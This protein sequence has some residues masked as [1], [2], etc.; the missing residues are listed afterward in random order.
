MLN[1]LKP[2]SKFSRNVLTLMTG[3]TI[4][5]AIPI[6]ISPILTRI[7]TPEDFGIFALYIAI[8][9]FISII[10]TARYE[11][12]I[13][14]PKKDEDAVN[15]LFLSLCIMMFIVI[16]TTILIL[17]F[18][19]TIIEL[20]NAKEIG[21][22]IYLIPISIFIAGLNQS[23]NYWS[24]R[25]EYFKNMSSAQISQ[26]I[27]IGIFQPLLG[28]FNIFG[29]LIIGNILGRVINTF[30]LIN[31]FISND[32]EKIK[33]VNKNIMIEQ[34]K[35]YKDFPL[36]N[37]LHA[38]TDIL[39][40]SGSVMLISSFFG[41]TIL[42]LYS[43][44]LRVLQV[45][46][47]I[48]GSALGKVLYSKLTLLYNDK[49]PLYPYVKKISINLFLISLPIFLFLYIIIPDLFGF[50]FGEKWRIA[51][52]YSK[53]LLPYLFVN[54][55]ISPI[56]IVPI[57]VKKQKEYFYLNLIANIGMPL[58]ILIG[59]KLSLSFIEILEYL[60]LFLSIFYILMLLWILKESKKVI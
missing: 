4:A 30:I 49:K 15:I 6:A 33:F 19:T 20:L 17:L 12:A 45:P 31:K 52:E 21:N 41:S 38:F 10:V 9:S 42:G 40:I 36:I 5:Q 37:S 59:F 18:K 51:G 60:T 57:I 27:T 34:M 25:K 22:F 16:V 26:S 43:L 1:K 55:V 24:N 58:I 35:I 29:G 7:Y 47:G 2:K 11:M 32:K 54:F 28:Y 14:L 53:I 3:T 44:S 48:V 39:R 46:I 23:F 50:V 8:V 56:S 13:V